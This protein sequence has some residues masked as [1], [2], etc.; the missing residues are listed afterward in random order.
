MIN[1]K[2][3]TLSLVLK[4]LIR[5]LAQL[6]MAQGM[7]Y[8]DFADI[9]KTA[10]LEEAQS[11]LSKQEAKPTISHI[12]LISGLHRKEV[13]QFVGENPE[14]PIK[15]IVTDKNSGSSY[16]GVI[17]EWISNPVFAG[18]DGKPAVLPYSASGT[19]PSFSMLVEKISKDVRPNVFL[20][21][22]Q[23]LGLIDISG[24]KNETIALQMDAFV[25]K[26]NFEEKIGLFEHNIGDHLKAA[27]SNMGNDAPP[28][29]ERS[30]FHNRL[31]PQDVELLRQFINKDGMD[32]LKTV[33]KNAKDL[34]EKSDAAGQLKSE[35]EQRI[36]C[37]LYFYAEPNT[38]SKDKI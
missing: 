38:T 27:V 13:S 3:V 22:M 35:S 29:F 2:N 20:S 18:T 25:P 31:S 34:S 9:G 11:L 23:R 15:R 4:R 16:A 1:N 26:D 24:D 32:F 30:A 6:M 33:Y 17:A 19:T 14:A 10:F 28:F 12:S 21:E 36:T 37:G 8:R 7:T 5:P